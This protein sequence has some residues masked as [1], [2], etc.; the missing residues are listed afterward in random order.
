ME[1]LLYK[2]YIALIKNSV[3]T[4][5]FRN[6]FFVVDWKTIDIVKN[7]SDAC[8]YFVSSVLKIFGLIKNIHA[9]VEG[10]VKDISTY[11]WEEAKGKNIQIWSLLIWEE[12]NWHKHI[13][14]YIWNHKAISNSSKKREI[15]KHSHDY[16]KKRKIEKIYVNSKMSSEL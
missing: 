10:T 12:M 14:F 8:S 7:G 9:T 1:Q 5:M 2:S 15:V 11:W 3:W 6:N 13:G 4:K 16:N